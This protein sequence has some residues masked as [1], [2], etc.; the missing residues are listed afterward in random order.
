[1]D[2]WTDGWMD[3][4]TYDTLLGHVDIVEET[5]EEFS[6]GWGVYTL[7][8]LL[9]PSLNTLLKTPIITHLFTLTMGIRFSYANH[10]I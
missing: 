8:S 10:Q 4:W 9:E 5:N 2:G 6:S 3:G 1:M 7:C